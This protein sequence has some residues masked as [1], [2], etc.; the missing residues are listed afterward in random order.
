MTVASS[1]GR[2][3]GERPVGA[4]A[5]RDEDRVDAEE[6]LLGDVLD[7]H[8][9]LRPFKPVALQPR[10]DMSLKA[11]HLGFFSRGSGLFV[12]VCGRRQDRA[13]DH[14]IVQPLLWD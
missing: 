12:D 1:A 8:H 10:E 14:I 6:V 5:D 9:P 3:A 7:S 4:S 11:T 2:T 13:D